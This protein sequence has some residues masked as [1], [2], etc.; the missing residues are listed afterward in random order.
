[1][2]SSTRSLLTDNC[3]CAPPILSPLLP[4]RIFA[5]NSVTSST[6]VSRALAK[7]R[8][9]LLLTFASLSQ[10]PT[11]SCRP[12]SRPSSPSPTYHLQ[13]LLHRLSALQSPSQQ[14][15]GTRGSLP[16]PLL[17][18]RRQSRRVPPSA[19]GQP[20]PATAGWTTRAATRSPRSYHLE[21][22]SRICLAPLLLIT[23]L[24]AARPNFP[25]RPSRST[26]TSPSPTTLVQP[27]G[28]PTAS[29]FSPV[30]TGACP[31][32]KWSSSGSLAD[33]SAS[34]IISGG[35]ALVGSRASGSMTHRSTPDRQ[36]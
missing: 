25:H 3:S 19:P 35:S 7:S 4:Y 27:S 9:V 16:R 24:P 33:P 11:R 1:L 32:S 8:E 6:T 30:V 20:P 26:A 21:Q 17:P 29:L 31:L 10:R 2:P 12:S 36:G 14:A 28:V 34:T 22:A 23:L 18:P 15:H 5:S 13:P